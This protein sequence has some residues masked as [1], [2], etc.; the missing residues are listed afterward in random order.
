MRRLISSAA[1]T[2]VTQS[3]LCLP[4]RPMGSQ[5]RPHADGTT[6]FLWTRLRKSVSKPL[7]NQPYTEA[8]SSR[9]CCG[10]PWL[11]QSRAILIVAL[12]QRMSDCPRYAQATR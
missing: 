2:P 4:C 3:A 12:T 5:S 10:L 9:V 8:S 1:G 11:R 6:S 7:L